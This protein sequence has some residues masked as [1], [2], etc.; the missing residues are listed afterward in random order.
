MKNK[1]KIYNLINAEN[2]T[3]INCTID[4]KEDYQL[5]KKIVDEIKDRPILM[6]NIVK[7]FKEKPELININKNSDPY[8]GYKKSIRRDDLV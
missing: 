2:L 8:Y 3:H 5:V 6:K 4:N 7:L 1:F